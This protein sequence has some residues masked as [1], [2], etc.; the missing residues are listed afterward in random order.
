MHPGVGVNL[1]TAVMLCGYH[2]EE[3]IMQKQPVG[4]PV[5]LVSGRI[6]NKVE[7]KLQPVDA[8][9]HDANVNARVKVKCYEDNVRYVA[10]EVAEAD[11]DGGHALV[12]GR[13]LGSNLTIGYHF[14]M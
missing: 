14:A 2:A 11:D 13:Q 3:G 9:E 5:L 7:A 12:P 8:L 1:H 10:E 4:L 6:H